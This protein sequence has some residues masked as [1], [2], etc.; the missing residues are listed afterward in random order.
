ME[1]IAYSFCPSPKITVNGESALV[2]FLKNGLVT[3]YPLTDVGSTAGGRLTFRL[4]ITI[5]P[6]AFPGSNSSSL[7]FV[8]LVNISEN[9]AMQAVRKYTLYFIFIVILCLFI[10]ILSPQFSLLEDIV[11]FCLIVGLPRGT[12]KLFSYSKYIFP[13]SSTI[14]GLLFSGIVI[15]TS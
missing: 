2:L 14:L 13:I 1:F 12:V 9:K 6:V 10:I 3:A 15:V 5:L 7:S 11:P 4:T 8:Q